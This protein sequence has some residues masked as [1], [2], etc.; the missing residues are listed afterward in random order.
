VRLV[1]VYVR[2]SRLE[3]LRHPAFSVPSLAFPAMFFLF[4]VA[5]RAGRDD[6]DFFLASYAGFAVLGIAFFQFGVGLAGERA[7][8]WEVYLRTLPAPTLVRL[9]GRVLS[10]LEFALAAVLLV[11]VA[12]VATT[13]VGLA[14]VRWLELAVTL[15]LGAIPFGLLGIAIGYWASPKAAL[16][17]ANVLYLGL[18]YAGGLWTRPGD[19]PDAIASFSPYLPTRQYAEALWNAV[20]GRPWSGAHWLYLTLYALAFAA[21][22]F[23]GYRRDEGQRYR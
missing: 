14:P 6:A 1:R 19:L 20:L 2:A 5:P 23:A 7:S 16:P 21:L 3:L 8:P 13:E 11:A 22:A 9:F 17:L 10:A 12:A 18:S 15:A 4:F